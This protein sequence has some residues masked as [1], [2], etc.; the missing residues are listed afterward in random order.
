MIPCTPRSIHQDHERQRKDKVAAETADLALRPRIT[1]GSLDAGEGCHRAPKHAICRA[2][3]GESKVSILLGKASR[4]VLALSESDEEGRTP[5]G[6][7]VLAGHPRVVALL[8][9]RKA[10]MDSRDQQGNTVLMLAAGSP[11][12]HAL[13]IVEL[14]LSLQADVQAENKEQLRAVDLA[15]PKVRSLLRNY[16]DR[17]E[18][19]LVARVRGWRAKPWRGGRPRL[20]PWIDR[21]EAVEGLVEPAPS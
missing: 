11:S 6:L 21:C 7:A 3:T 16:M 1:S 18:A 2:G 13:S 8:L 4:S 14:L 12:R 20:K 9:D 15:V 5:L 17:M 10:S 19:R